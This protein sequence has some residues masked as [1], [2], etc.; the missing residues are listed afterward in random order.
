MFL[1]NF[2]SLLTLIS[3]LFVQV[4][5]IRSQHQL[6]RLDVDSSPL[7]ALFHHPQQHSIRENNHSSLQAIKKPR[8]GSALIHRQVTIQHKSR[9]HQLRNQLLILW[10]QIILLQ[11]RSHLHERIIPVHRR[12]LQL[13]G[14][15]VGRRHRLP[16]LPR[17]HQRQRLAYANQRETGHR[18][19][20]EPHKVGDPGKDA[21]DDHHQN[22]IERTQDHGH[23]HSW[24]RRESNRYHQGPQPR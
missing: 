9:R 14:Y 17:E 23:E 16:L 19:Q 6:G 24:R 20:R 15:Q 10:S 13:L 18:P 2:T 8:S 1:P 12:F 11:N 3:A 22:S 5:A 21:L 4:Q 7:T